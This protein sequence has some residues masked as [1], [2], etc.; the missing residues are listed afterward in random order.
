MATGK[1]YDESRFH[2]EVAV[3]LDLG[4]GDWTVDFVKGLDSAHAMERARR[5]WPDAKEIRYGGTVYKANASYDPATGVYKRF[6]LDDID[7]SKY[8]ST[9]LKFKGK[10]LYTAQE[11]QHIE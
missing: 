7:V 2:T 6:S 11:L 10:S 8:P 4:D 3:V 5:N 9:G 1:G